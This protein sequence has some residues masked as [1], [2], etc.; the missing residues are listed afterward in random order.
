MYRDYEVK[1]CIYNICEGIDI[2]PSRIEN[3]ILDSEMQ[4]KK[5]PID[6]MFPSLLNKFIE[7]NRYDFVLIDCPP[8]MGHI[9]TAAPSRLIIPT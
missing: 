4:T 9:V 7:E 3:V 6:K 2:L 5:I 8:T 1:D